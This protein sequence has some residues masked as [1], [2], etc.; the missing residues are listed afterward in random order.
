[1]TCY[2]KLNLITESLPQL[3]HHKDTIVDII[4]ESLQVGVCFSINLC[5]GMSTHLTQ[6]AVKGGHNTIGKP[7]ALQI[8]M[9][10]FQGVNGVKT[11]FETLFRV[12][13][14]SEK[15]FEGF[16]HAPK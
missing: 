10:R 1:M 12:L 6:W 11:M 3:L 4:L 13:K 8:Q 7:R 14:P 15:F 2:G 5:F 16:L 9:R